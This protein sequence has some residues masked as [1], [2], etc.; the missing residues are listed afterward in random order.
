[1]ATGGPV[2]AGIGTAVGV[3]V[4][5]MVDFA[6]NLALTMSMDTGR[7]LLKSLLTNSNGSI[8]PAVASVISAFARSA[9]AGPEETE[10]PK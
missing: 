5:P 6:K 10:V 4:P 3:A 2:G 7:A 9:V 8:T 1:M